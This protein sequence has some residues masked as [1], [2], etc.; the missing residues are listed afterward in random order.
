VRDLG[1][2]PVI[3]GAVNSLSAQELGADYGDWYLASSAGAGLERAVGARSSVMLAADWVRVDSLTAVG[4]PARGTW[5]RANPGVDEGGW[6]TLRLTLR[7]RSGSFATTAEASGR[8]EIEAGVGPL[9]YG[10]AFAEGRWQRPLVGG[11]L[12]LRGAGGVLGGEAPRH[13]AF[14]LGGR[15]TLLGSAFRGA[16]GRRIAWTSAEWQRPVGVP[17]LRLGSFAGTGRAVTLAPN[18]ALGWAGGAVPGFPAVPLR[19]PE[20]TVGLGFELFHRLLRVDVGWAVRTGAF[21][22]AVDVSRDFWDIL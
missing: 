2:V 15:G 7:R 20:A 14:V 11:T 13:R 16:G 18:I 5:D 3:S 10:R 12:V 1:D 9:D 4:R 17:E 8:L 19:G 6:A 21:G 22:A